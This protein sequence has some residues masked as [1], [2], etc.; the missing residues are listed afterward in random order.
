MGKSVATQRRD[1]VIARHCATRQWHHDIGPKVPKVY[2]YV[3]LIAML[4]FQ[5]C[6]A[7]AQFDILMHVYACVSAMAKWHQQA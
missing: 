5:P 1:I 7:G 6:F 4:M 2:N 3:F